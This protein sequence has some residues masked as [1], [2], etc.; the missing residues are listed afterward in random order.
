M[1][2]SSATGVLSIFVA[3]EY[4]GHWKVFCKNNHF[5]T[6]VYLCQSVCHCNRGS[7]RRHVP[8]AGSGITDLTLHPAR[9]GE[10][11]PGQGQVIS[12]PWPVYI[13]PLGIYFLPLGTRRHRGAVEA[14]DGEEDKKPALWP[15]KTLGS[16]EPR[17]ENFNL[18]ASYTPCDSGGSGEC[19][20]SR[21]LADLGGRQGDSLVERGTLGPRAGR[22][23]PC[24]PRYRS[25]NCNTSV[26][27]NAGSRKAAETAPG[28]RQMRETRGTCFANKII[29]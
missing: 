10:S 7:G 3:W 12:L 25:Q 20:E 26:N 29:N 21:G 5:T 14:P 23:I 11:H 17:R 13:W 6:R 8:K 16:W 2:L 27:G 9:W 22:R 4:S 28:M 1:K 15:G 18:K 24:W 19:G